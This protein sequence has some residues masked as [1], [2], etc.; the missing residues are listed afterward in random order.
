MWE[1]LSYG[2]TNQLMKA[3]VAY[4]EIAFGGEYDIN[5]LDDD[6]FSKLLISLANEFKN[7]INDNIV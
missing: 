1:T 6:A 5:K 4:I 3:S 7:I 2:E